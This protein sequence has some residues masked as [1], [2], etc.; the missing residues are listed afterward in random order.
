[1]FTMVATLLE[2]RK[3]SDWPLLAKIAPHLHKVEK[4]LTR[5]ASLPTMHHASDSPCSIENEWKT[6]CRLHR[7]AAVDMHRKRERRRIRRRKRR[8]T[9]RRRRRKK[10]N[11]HL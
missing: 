4:I 8:T 7:V 9:R 2:T 6:C 11:G 10:E 3:Q 5:I 1:M